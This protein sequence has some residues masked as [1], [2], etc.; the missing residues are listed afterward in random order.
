MIP[1]V[2]RDLGVGRTFDE[3]CCYTIYIMAAIMVSSIVAL[4]YS[5]E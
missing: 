5:R 1:M 3:Y 4:A 2:L